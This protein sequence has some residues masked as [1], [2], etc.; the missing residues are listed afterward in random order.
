MYSGNHSPANPLRTL[1]DATTAG[2]RTTTRSA[3]FFVGGG[4]GKKEV[5]SH[6]QGPEPD[7]RDQLPLPAVI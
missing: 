5:E 3:S 6:N 2:S 1:L 7:E 4:I